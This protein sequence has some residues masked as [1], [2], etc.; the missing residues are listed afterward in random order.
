VV[1]K[2]IRTRLGLL[3]E[4]LL[5]ELSYLLERSAKLTVSSYLLSTIIA[6]LKNY[7]AHVIALARKSLL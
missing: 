2:T 7:T 3:L 4:E 5:L 1:F 6:S